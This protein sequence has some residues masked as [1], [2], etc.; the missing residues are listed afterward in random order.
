MYEGMKKASGPRVIKVAPLKSV[1]GEII[2]DCSKQME[3]RV[4]HYQE[5]FS[6]ENIGDKA[7]EYTTPLPTMEDL[8]APPTIDE[9]R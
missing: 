6:R 8:D 7:I 5:L 2:K 3:R 1:S 4:E 9:L